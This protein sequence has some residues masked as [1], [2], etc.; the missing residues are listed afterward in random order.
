LPAALFRPI[1]KDPNYEILNIN[2]FTPE[3]LQF[4]RKLPKQK[5]LQ[6]IF[7]KFSANQSKS[8]VENI[9]GVNISKNNNVFSHD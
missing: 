6:K 4:P 5:I 7:Q 8:S 3:K 2:H 1:H 9:E